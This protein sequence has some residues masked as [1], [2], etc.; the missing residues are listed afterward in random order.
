MGKEFT[1]VWQRSRK[2]L[3]EADWV[4]Y[5][6][7]NVPH[8]TIENLDHS[9]FIDNCILIESIWW[10]PYHNSYVEKLA[11]K[12]YKF[13]L[14]HLSDETLQTTIDSYKH[15]KFVIRNYFRK[16]MAS[17]VLQVPLG[18][19]SGFAKDNFSQPSRKYT[20]SC[21][22]GRWDPNRN[23][24]A[25]AMSRVPNGSLYVAGRDGPSLSPSSMKEK[26]QNAIFVPCPRGN[27]HIDSF[28]VTEALEAGCIPIVEQ[29]DYW[30]EMH[31]ENFP[32]IQIKDWND[33][34]GIIASLI[35]SPLFLEDLRLK[36]KEWWQ[37]RKAKVVDQVTDL[38]FSTMK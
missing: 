35:G 6:F 17:N 13:G 2:E 9:K 24:M 22:A 11:S 33:A 32:A 21:V 14:M 20:W 18:Y 28:R 34:P 10:A 23:A 4:E 31:G 25:G 27:Y 3:W 1:I 16:G 37:A 19:I 26:Y 8:Q 7:Q 30:R 29:S 36:A 15:C 5:L 38:V 12:G